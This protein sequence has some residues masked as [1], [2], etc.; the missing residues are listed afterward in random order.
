MDPSGAYADPGFEVEGWFIIL[1]VIITLLL[2]II[3]I[4]CLIKSQKGGKYYVS[5]KEDQLKDDVEFSPVKDQGGF[6]EFQ[7]RDDEK[8][9]L[10]HGSQPSLNESEPGSSETDSLKEYAEGSMGKFDEEGSF[11][12]QYGDK[13]MRSPD[14]DQDGTGGYATF[15]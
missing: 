10:T 1:I 6:D 9:P 5:D 13:K 3:L 8:A 12:G 15:V 4:V 11:I 7:P 2:L 14:K